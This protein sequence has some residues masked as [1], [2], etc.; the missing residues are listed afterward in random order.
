[1]LPEVKN[2]F[3]LVPAKYQTLLLPC[4]RKLFDLHRIIRGTGSYVAE[5]KIM[6]AKKDHKVYPN[7]YSFLSESSH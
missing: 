3:N 7:D 4:Q 5:C 1:M 6:I 2:L